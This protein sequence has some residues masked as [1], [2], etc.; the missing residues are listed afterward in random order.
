MQNQTFFS[1]DEVVFLIRDIAGRFSSP[2]SSAATRQLCDVLSHMADESER[3]DS[4]CQI[5]IGSIGKKFTDMLGELRRSQDPEIVDLV[6]SMVFRFLTEYDL[7]TAETLT[8]DGRIF[9]QQMEL[10]ESNLSKKAQEQLDYCR[11]G[12]ALTIVKRSLNSAEMLNLRNLEEFSKSVDQRFDEWDAKLNAQKNDATRLGELFEKHARD[13]NFSG[14]HAGF[15]D[16]AERIVKELRFSQIGLAVFG[17]LLLLPCATEIYLA[18]KLFEGDWLPS[19]QLLI[20]S[21]IGTITL[22]LI[23][24]YFFR[25]S[26]RKADSC[27]AQLMQ[28]HLRM[29]LCRFIQPYTDYSKDVRENHSETFAK[30]ESLIFSGIV[31]TTEKLPSTFDGIDQLA[32]L[33]ASLRGEKK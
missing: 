19:V 26:L 4:L 25:I 33:V 13:F 15:S 18:S 21:G 16:M 6:S 12:M 28:I 31:G 3:F 17:V 24:L 5:N 7:S 8:M 2:E 32:T 30:F 20:A 9:I 27:R 11:K 10:R 14:L 22:T 23:F 29:S 1:S